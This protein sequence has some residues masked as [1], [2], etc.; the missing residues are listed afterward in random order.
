REAGDEWMLLQ[1]SRQ[2]ALQLA[3]TVTVNEP[4][5]AL[6]AQ[7]RFVKKTLRPRERLVDAATDDIQVG[8][9]RLAW[10][11]LDVD[12][13]ARDWRRATP[14]DS[15][16]AQA[17]SHPFP[18]HIELGGPIMDRCDERFETQSVDDNPI[19]DRGDRSRWRLR[20][21][22]RLQEPF[23]DCI[24][25]RT[26]LGAGPT[27]SPRPPALPRLPAPRPS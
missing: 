11:K 6:V 4:D 21:M 5:D 9:P 22:A 27:H 7:Q 16:V 20:L 12:V 26:R 15:Q 18:A 19:A 17:R 13:D 14:D 1:K 25:C 24:D 3:G 10:L 2:R 23:S 8:R